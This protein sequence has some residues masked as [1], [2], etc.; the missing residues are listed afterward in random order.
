MN[1]RIPLLAALLL[2]TSQPANPAQPK[3]NIV[4]YPRYSQAPASVRLTVR[5]QP[6]AANRVVCIGY[7]GPQFRSSCWQVEGANAAITTEVVFPDLPEGRYRAQGKVQRAG[8]G[9][10]QAEAGFCVLGI[11]T[12]VEE[13]VPG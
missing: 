2:L 6:D 11:E 8:G 4:V 9:V 12:G 3:I 5:V 10:E 13:C 7:D 1:S